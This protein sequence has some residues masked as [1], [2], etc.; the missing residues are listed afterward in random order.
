[1]AGM[2]TAGTVTVGAGR[3]VV[4]SGLGAGVIHSNPAIAPAVAAI[5][6]E[7]ATVPGAGVIVSRLTGRA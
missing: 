6:R 2:S 4:G 5:A 3:S 7:K 1:M